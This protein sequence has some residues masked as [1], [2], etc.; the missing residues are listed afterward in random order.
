MSTLAARTS[1]FALLQGLL[2]AAILALLPTKGSPALLNAQLI[3][4]GGLFCVSMM[5]LINY[6][7]AMARC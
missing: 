2:W 7:Q 1:M 5:S 4:A 6:P 3:G